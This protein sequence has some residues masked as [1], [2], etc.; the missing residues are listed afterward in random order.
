MSFWLKQGQRKIYCKGMIKHNG[1]KKRTSSNFTQSVKNELQIFVS[2]VNT[3]FKY[4]HTVTQNMEEFQTF[5]QVN[6]H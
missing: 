2:K 6:V 3:V 1:S 5:F 4:N